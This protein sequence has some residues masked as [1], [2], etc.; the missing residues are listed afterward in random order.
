MLFQCNVVCVS[1]YKYMDYGLDVIIKYIEAMY[2]V[3][4]GNHHII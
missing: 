4:N 1:H 2:S 3:Y